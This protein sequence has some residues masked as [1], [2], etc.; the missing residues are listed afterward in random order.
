[1]TEQLNNNT[2]TMTI[3][4]WEL[5]SKI[6]AI[7]KADR[8]S[9]AGCLVTFGI[10]IKSKYFYYYDSCNI[11]TVFIILK[12][13]IV[14]LKL[15]KSFLGS[16]VKNLPAIQETLIWALSQED[17]LE[18]GMET[19]SSILAWRITWTEEPGG[20][21]PMGSQRVV[22]DWVTNTLSETQT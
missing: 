10:Q 11:R 4:N 22:H 5:K 15:R 12:L 17:P 8:F 20:L 7:S 19:H 14:Y 13:L 1:M 2:K 6:D 18:K 21:Q 9:H 3:C 16:G